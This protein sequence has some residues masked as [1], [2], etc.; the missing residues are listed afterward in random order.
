MGDEM[1]KIVAFLRNIGSRVRRIQ[2]PGKV[3]CKAV[4]KLFQ[5]NPCQNFSVLPGNWP[6]PPPPSAARSPWASAETFALPR[7]TRSGGARRND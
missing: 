1:R 6:F 5:A 7:D 4:S 3:D 2:N